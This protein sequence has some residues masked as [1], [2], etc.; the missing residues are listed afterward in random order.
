LDETGRHADV[1]WIIAAAVTR[2]VLELSTDRPGTYILGRSFFEP[3]LA[4]RQISP[5]LPGRSS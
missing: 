3:S 4:V 1:R 2:L 5:A